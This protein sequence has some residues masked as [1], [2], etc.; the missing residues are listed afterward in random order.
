MPS[1]ANFIALA[2]IA[3]G[4]AGG[5][6]YTDIKLGKVSNLMVFAAGAAG[7]AVSTFWS[8]TDGAFRSLL[9]CAVGL[10]LILPGYLAGKVGAGGAKLLASIGAIGG[11]SFALASLFWGCIIAV[12]SAALKEKSSGG[13][14]GVLTSLFVAIIPPKSFSF[15]DGND[16]ACGS[17]RAK[18]SEGIPFAAAI[19]AGA[20]LSLFLLM[21][22]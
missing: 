8:G 10:L 7:I 2:L 19:G 13:F 1:D 17:R 12:A 15:R 3:G 14:A 22:R 6:I 16:L 9:G 11:A 18:G 4:L 5:S 20:L 21:F